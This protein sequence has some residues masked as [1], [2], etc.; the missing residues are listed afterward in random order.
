MAITPPNK[1]GGLERERVVYAALTLLDEA[2]FAGLSLRKLAARLHVQAAALYWHFKD[3]QD[4]ID[5]MAG[6][7]MRQEFNAV[8]DVLPDWR[9]TLTYIAHAQRR[10]LMR[11]RD[12]AE[13]IAHANMRKSFNADKREK[14]L[15]HLQ[16]Y[17]FSTDL[18]L[19]S[20]FSIVRYTLGCAFEEQA[21][22]RTVNGTPP[23]FDPDV[24]YEAGL[25]IILEGVATRLSAKD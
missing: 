18:A 5:A 6:E 22:P 12:G 3:K 14:L 21:D 16:T 7:I 24:L 9:I 19:T 23:L 20:L 2:G 1:E 25:S 17:G 10:A 11:Y 15:T 4:L 13:V 8:P